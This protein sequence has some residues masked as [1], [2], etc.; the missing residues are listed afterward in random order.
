MFL[1]IFDN[2][3]IL[4][5]YLYI[6]FVY[7]FKRGLQQWRHAKIRECSFWGFDSRLLVIFDIWSYGFLVFWFSIYSVKWCNIRSIGFIFIWSRGIR[8]NGPARVNSVHFYFWIVYNSALNK[9]LLYQIYN[10]ETG[11]TVLLCLQNFYSVSDFLDWIGHC[12]STI[13]ISG[14]EN[15]SPEL[16]WTGS[17]SGNWSK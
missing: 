10:F 8:S 4:N 12:S 2:N 13:R 9:D 5:T 14:K 6:Y 15:S 7:Y 16:F 11:L 1:V 3:V 17:W